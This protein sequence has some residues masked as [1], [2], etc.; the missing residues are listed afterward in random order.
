MAK[1]KKAKA[2]LGIGVIGAGGIAE[3]AHLPGY[4]AYPDL[5]KIVAVCDTMPDR[6]KRVAEKFGAEHVFTDYRDMLALKSVDAVSVTTPNAFHKQ[7]TI[8]SLK[9]GKHVLVEK[10]L[11]MNSAEGAEMVRVAR[12]TGMKLQVGLNMRWGSDQQT[13]KRFIDEGKLG[14][15]YYARA[16]ALRRR[17]VPTWGVFTEKDKQGGGPMIDIGV[18]I[19]DT[20]LWLM[21]HPKPVSVSGM[22]CRK[23]GHRSGILNIWGPWDPNNF[24]VE[25]FACGLVKF[26]NGAAMSIESS[27]VANL[28]NDVFNSTLLGTEGGAQLSPLKLFREE[29]GALIEVTPTWRPNLPPSHQLEIE[30]FLKAILEDTE[31][32]VTGEQGLMTQQIIEAVYTSSE[33]GREVLLP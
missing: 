16:Q 33:T 15:I 5:C 8:D 21:G 19:I 23:F 14:D 31:P 18:H 6:A 26:E 2:P 11:A 13:L 12:E 1:K 32:L 28:E 7:P 30:A 29:C 25:D 20:T 22:S 24:T 17:G 4:A 3:G 27:F 9:A 10:P